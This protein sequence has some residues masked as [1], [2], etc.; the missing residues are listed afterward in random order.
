MGQGEVGGAA[1]GLRERI[2]AFI[3]EAFFVDGFGDDESF[4]ARGI[5]DSMGLVQLVAFLEHDLGIRVGD[6]ELLPENLDSL[7][8]VT[9]FAG[10][11]LGR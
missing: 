1:S 6:D 5:I 11:K 10:R 4:L 2:R 9:A 3:V 8:R 7:A